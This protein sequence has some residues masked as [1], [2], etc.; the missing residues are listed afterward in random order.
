MGGQSSIERV[1]PLTCSPGGPG[2]RRTRH[3]GGG[4]VVRRAHPEPA[5]RGG[6][7]D[8]GRYGSG[9]GRRTSSRGDRASRT[10]DRAGIGAQSDARGHRRERRRARGGDRLPNTIDDRDHSGRG[11]TWEPFAAPKMST[12]QRVT[13]DSD[14]FI[15]LIGLAT[16]GCAPSYERSFSGRRVGVRPRRA[17]GVVV[18]R[19]PNRAGLHAPAGD[20]P[21]P[22]GT[23]VQLAVIDESSA[24]V[25]CDDASVYATVDA[26]Q[27]WMPPVSVPGASAISA[28]GAGY[29]LVVVNQNECVGAHV[30]EIVVTDADLRLTAPGS[31]LPAAIAP[32]ETALAVGED[33]T[34]LWAGNAFARSEDGG[35]TW[36]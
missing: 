15:A 25:L 33:V 30:V 12:V 3:G 16:E 19:S 11:G 8:A 31:C 28:S 7:L 14:A 13:V 23:V 9:R 2:R 4:T 35:A 27:G 24:A 21:A 18:R 26:G 22:C 10:R 5:S 32:G 17:L 20:R 34:W 1:S 29:R 6:G 36:L